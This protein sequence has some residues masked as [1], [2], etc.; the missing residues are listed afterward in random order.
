LRFRLDAFAEAKTQA[1]EHLG[2]GT[3]RRQLGPFNA[4]LPQFL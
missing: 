1:I 3:G 4:L 2:H